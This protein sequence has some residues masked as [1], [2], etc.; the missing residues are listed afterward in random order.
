[1]PDPAT[2]EQVEEPIMTLDVITPKEYVGGVMGLVAERKGVYLTTDYLSAGSD[3]RALIHYR[4]PLASLITDF[5]DKL[6][7][8]PSVPVMRIPSVM[9]PA[10][11][12][13]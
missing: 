3:Q 13:I 4:I 2:I 6:K 9:V 11:S 10:V 8:L 1:M 5:Y 7:I 12:A